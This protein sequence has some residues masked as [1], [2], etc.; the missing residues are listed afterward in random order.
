MTDWTQ[1]VKLLESRRKGNAPRSS[2][3]IR[4]GNLLDPA[5][6]I[7]GSQGM[8]QHLL[9]QGYDVYL[10]DVDIR[11]DYL[12][13]QPAGRLPDRNLGWIV[14][15]ALA[16]IP[17]LVRLQIY[18]HARFDIN[19]TDPGAELSAVPI[20]ERA[21]SEYN[22]HRVYIRD[23]RVGRP[24]PGMGFVDIFTCMTY[25]E[26]R[27]PQLLADTLGWPVRSV[28]PGYSIYFPQ[29]RRFPCSQIPSLRALSLFR[30][31][32][33][34]WALWFP[35]WTSIL[36]AYEPSERELSSIEDFVAENRFRRKLGKLLEPF[37]ESRKLRAKRRQA[38]RILAMDSLPELAATALDSLE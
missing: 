25:P 30:S 20:V 11:R 31:D 5:L 24:G 12:E 27:W 2:L 28:A 33:R 26:V 7:Q 35:G 23:L 4:G 15:A 22:A 8:I 10:L 29:R 21:P 19:L 34:G 13:F 17:N 14:Q 3:L 9:V 16:E 37:R 32:P 36:P 6:F 1:H 18:A 38:A